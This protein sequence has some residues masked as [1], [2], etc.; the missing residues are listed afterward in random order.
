MR[1]T[2]S[3]LALALIALVSLACG[4]IG[5]GTNSNTANTN[6]AG[7]NTAGTT[8]GQPA[9]GSSEPA[10]RAAPTAAQQ[11]A[12]EGGQT[13]EWEQQN[14]RWTVP[15]RWTRMSAERQNLHWRSPGTWDAGNLLVTI[16]PMDS[17]FPVEASIRAFYDQAMTR[18]RNGEVVR[19]RWL[20][21]DGVRGIEFLE[22]SPENAED[23]RR[24]QWQGYR[25]YL[26]QTQ[27]IN[28]M[29]TAQGRHFSH[30]ENALHGIL[31]S[32]KFGQ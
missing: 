25:T 1:Q 8:T 4:L 30:H 11:A 2:P 6:G 21:L 29:L 15:P 20:E 31:Y 16:S 9:G 19:V 10:E 12:L 23:P 13:I 32:T 17:S 27:L 5:G 26:G 3:L 18:Q 7:A 24:L 28:I 14:I 22:E